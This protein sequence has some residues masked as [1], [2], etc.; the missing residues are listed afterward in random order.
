MTQDPRKTPDTALYVAH[1]LKVAGGR[2]EIFT[3]RAIRRLYRLS[4][5]LPRLINIIADRSLLAAYASDEHLIGASLVGKAASEVFG[6]S[7]ATRWWPW[8]AALTGVAILTFVTLTSNDGDSTD[9]LELA[10]AETPPANLPRQVS[11]AVVGPE[12]DSAESA[13]SLTFLLS[14]ATAAP[15]EAVVATLFGLWNADYSPSAGSVCEQ[16]DA[17]ALRCLELAGLTIGDIRRL[18]RP[19]ALELLTGNGASHR[20]VLLG[21]GRSNADVWI[22]GAVRRIATAELDAFTPGESLLLF[23]PAV[24][25]K[26]GALAEGA[27]GPSVIW[28]RTSLESLGYSPITGGGSDRFDTGLTAAIRQFQSDSGV[29]VNGLVDDYTL[30]RLQSEIG[31]IGVSMQSGID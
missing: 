12:P 17:Q 25:E 23:R 22:N 2:P 18:Y 27:Q 29:T 13:A 7:R 24:A 1:R 15:E 10:A 4:R 16:A 3:R 20:L 8:A 21:L 28:L 11:S 30:A 6:R 5:G 14:A 26:G 19:V 9:V 31:L